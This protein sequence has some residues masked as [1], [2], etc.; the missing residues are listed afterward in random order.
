MIVQLN[1]TQIVI[2][3]W[4]SLS[5]LEISDSETHN[6]LVFWPPV[7]HRRPYVQLSQLAVHEPIIKPIIKPIIG[8]F[9]DVVSNRSETIN[10]QLVQNSIFFLIFHYFH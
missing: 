7:N 5:L 6:V 1:V 3:T 10:L 8:W 9:V 4:N 2:T